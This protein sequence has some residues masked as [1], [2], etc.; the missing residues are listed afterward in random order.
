MFDLVYKAGDA[1]QVILDHSQTLL[2]PGQIVQSKLSEKLD[3]PFLHVVDGKTKHF[4]KILK[5]VTSNIMI[6]GSLLEDIF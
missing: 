6:T 3:R 5:A 2:V 4:Q 1:E